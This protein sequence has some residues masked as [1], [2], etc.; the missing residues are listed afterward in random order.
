MKICGFKALG[1]QGAME[2]EAGSGFQIPKPWASMAKFGKQLASCCAG[3]QESSDQVHEI[4]RR[5]VMETM[6]SEFDK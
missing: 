4:C 1:F 3:A 6:L 5:Q 2:L